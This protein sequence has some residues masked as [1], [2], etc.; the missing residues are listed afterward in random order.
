MKKENREEEE[1]KEIWSSRAPK[2]KEEVIVKKGLRMLHDLEIVKAA[3]PCKFLYT[4]LL[5]LYIFR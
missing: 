2:I 4:L 3:A 1:P 5:S